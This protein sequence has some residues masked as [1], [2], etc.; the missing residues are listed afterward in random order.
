M[1]QCVSIPLF[2]HFWCSVSL[3]VLS[4][5]SQSAAS[6]A[7]TTRSFCSNTTHLQTTSSS[8]W[9]MP[10]TSRREIWWRWCSQVSFSSLLFSFSPPLLSSALLFSSLLFFLLL[11]VLHKYG[12]LRQ[13]D[14]FVQNQYHVIRHVFNLLE[15]RS[16]KWLQPNHL[17]FVHIVT[18]GC[19][20]IPSLCAQ[21]GRLPGRR[22]RK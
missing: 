10:A 6:M 3:R 9:K 21:E 15:W 11:S 20:Q 4:S 13:I 18:A 1:S 7:S 12:K 17:G 14:T 19:T 2:A 22:S 8:W 5:S 16:Y